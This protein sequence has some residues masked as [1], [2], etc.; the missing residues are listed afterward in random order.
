MSLPF[1]ARVFTA[2]ETIFKSRKAL[3]LHGVFAAFDALAEEA[4]AEKNGRKMT[5]AMLL[6]MIEKAI[7]IRYNIDTLAR[8]RKSTQEDVEATIKA[9]DAIGYKPFAELLPEASNG[10]K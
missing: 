1:S 5:N 7:G 4:K 6:D 9:C 10:S 3:V 2:L 8:L